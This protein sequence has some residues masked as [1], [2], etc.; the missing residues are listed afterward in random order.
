VLRNEPGCRQGAATGRFDRDAARQPTDTAGVDNAR[1]AQVVEHTLGTGEDPGSTPDVGSTRED[2]SWAG[3]ES[4]ARRWA[5]GFEPR[6]GLTARGSTPPLSSPPAPG[7][8]RAEPCV[9]GRAVARDLSSQ[10]GFD[11]RQTLRPILC[12]ELQ[13]DPTTLSSAAEQLVYAEP[14]ARSN[15][16]ASTV[17][18]ERS[19]T[20]VST[21]AGH[22][23]VGRWALV[24]YM[25]VRVPPAT[26]QQRPP[27]TPTV[28]QP[29]R[30][31]V[32][33]ATTADTLAAEL[34]DINAAYADI[35]RTL[36]SWLQSGRISKFD[37]AGC[38]CFSD[39]SGYCG[40]Q[41]VIAIKVDGR[42]A[43]IESHHGSFTVSKLY[44]EPVR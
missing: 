5:T 41:N 39:W 24:P 37:L 40:G 31:T 14:V 22:S 13:V 36:D 17:V 15:R 1:I 3:M 42:W 44:A 4:A 23:T 33:L 28:S 8:G 19:G 38:G 2:T 29:E 25:G 9:C 18:D 27:G 10:R 26:Q 20:V 34:T 21:V 30:F 32:T 35:E 43:V 11:S 6:G 16:A 12:R 7:D